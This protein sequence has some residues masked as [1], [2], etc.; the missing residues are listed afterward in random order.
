MICR[1][2]VSWIQSDLISPSELDAVDASIERVI[3]SGDV[4]GA[5]SDRGSVHAI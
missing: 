3:V 5:A 1:A 2:K 4:K